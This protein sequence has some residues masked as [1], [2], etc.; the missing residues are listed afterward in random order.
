MKL[1]FFSVSYAGDWGQVC[2]DGSAF[3]AK[4][5]D[6]LV[7]AAVQSHR[8]LGVRAAALLELPSEGDRPNCNAVFDAWSAALCGED[9]L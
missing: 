2:L 3:L 7:T 6:R 4:A 1:S 9:A 8:D 5:A